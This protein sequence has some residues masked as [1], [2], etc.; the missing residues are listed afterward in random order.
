[1]NGE[2]RL[3]LLLIEVIFASDETVLKVQ[4]THENRDNI[5]FTPFSLKMVERIVI[6]KG[7]PIVSRKLF[8][9]GWYFCI[10]E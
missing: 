10:M 6:I 4:M 8:Y 5:V 7:L 1:M 9:F 3:M 2:A